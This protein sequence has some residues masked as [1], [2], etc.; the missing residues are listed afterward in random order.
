[1]E[2]GARDWSRIK[3]YCVA[4][5]LF[6]LVLARTIGTG[7]QGHMDA[8]FFIVVAVAA[9]LFLVPLSVLKSL[10]A[11]SLEF[12]LQQPEVSAAIGGLQLTQVQNDELRLTLESAKDVLPSVRGSRVLWIDDHQEKCVLSRRR[13]QE[14]CLLWTLTTTY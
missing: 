4:G 13:T 12:T 9:A 11:G 2:K 8:I 10:K 1:M 6:G 3:Q 5:A 14:N 7:W